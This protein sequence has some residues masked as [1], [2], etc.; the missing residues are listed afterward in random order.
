MKILITGGYGF[1]G[2]FLIKELLKNKKYS[3]INIDNITNSSMP[4]SLNSIKNYKHYKFIKNDITN[5]T[6][7]NK[8]IFFH[9]PDSIIHLAAESHVDNS[10]ESP[11]LF[12]NTNILGTYNLLTISKKYLDN[13]LYKKN[14]FKFI[15]VSTD[16]VYGSLSMQASPK[17]ELSPFLP[18]SPYSST[19]ASS[20]LLVR[21][22]NKTYNFPSI[23]TNPVSAFSKVETIFFALLI[24]SSVGV[25]TL[26]NASI[27]LG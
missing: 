21:A 7:L 25:K 18:N 26:F 5:Y 23:T 27:C 3:I 6:S 16:E 24:S 14:K 8:I 9:K 12:I 17:K 19:K 1:I 10:I 2:S 20:D 22:W 4:E 15:H 11:K 13:H